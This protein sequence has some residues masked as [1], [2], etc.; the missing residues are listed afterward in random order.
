MV[1][2]LSPFARVHVMLGRGTP[3]AWQIISVPEIFK[4]I[5]D[6]IG[7]FGSHLGIR[8]TNIC[9]ICLFT[10]IVQNSVHFCFAW[11]QMTI[12]QLQGDTYLSDDEQG[13]VTLWQQCGLNTNIQKYTYLSDDEKDNPSLGFGLAK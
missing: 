11:F 12:M 5:K 3:R 10:M 6:I 7:A 2:I 8:H 9:K 4:E 13:F 1:P